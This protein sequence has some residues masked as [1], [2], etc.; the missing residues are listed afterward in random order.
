MTAGRRFPRVLTASAPWAT[1]AV[2]TRGTV[3]GLPPP[4]P[5]VVVID[6]CQALFMDPSSPGRLRPGKA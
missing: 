5:R 2:L 3:D 6:E 4:R 1:G